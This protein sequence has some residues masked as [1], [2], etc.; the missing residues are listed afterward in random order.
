MLVNIMMTHSASI[1]NFDERKAEWG[2]ENFVRK[3]DNESGP[4]L[5]AIKLVQ[6][7]REP[8]KRGKRVFD[9]KLFFESLSRQFGVKR[10][11]SDKQ[12]AAMKRMI[13]KYREQIPGY[14]K[15]MDAPPAPAPE[16]TE[17]S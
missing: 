8:V 5:E 2:L 10:A 16:T 4:M 13:K 3:D 1:P 12:R 17:E 14:E 6:Q 9:D 7:W 15:F 11:L